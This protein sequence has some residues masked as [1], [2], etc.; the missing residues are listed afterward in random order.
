MMKNCIEF[1]H[2]YK[3]K[4]ECERGKTKHGPLANILLCL[5]KAVEDVIMM[6]CVLTASMIIYRGY[7]MV[8]RRY[9]ISLRVLKNELTC[10]ISFQHKKRNFVSPSGHVMFYLS[11]KHQ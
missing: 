2:Q 1:Y 5:E 4:Y 11:Y 3:D 6:F 7:F 10:E 8:V 9:E